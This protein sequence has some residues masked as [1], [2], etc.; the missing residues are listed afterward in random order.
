MA[1]EVNYLDSEYNAFGPWIFE[2][3]DI[4]PMPPLFVP[5]YKEGQSCLMMIKVPRNINRRDAKPGMDLY[6]YVIGMYEK[7]VYILKRKDKEVEE[8]K[9]YYDEVDSIENYKDMLLGRLTIHLN[10]YT[11]IVPY[12]AVSGDIIFQLVKIIRDRYVQKEYEKISLNNKIQT[13]EVTEIL[14]KNLINE[15]NSRGDS[16]DI[17]AFQPAVKLKKKYEKLVEKLLR[18]IRPKL[19]LSTIHLINR[20]ELLVI[21]RGSPINYLRDALYSYSF[22]YIPIERINNIKLE[23]FEEYNDLQIV[24]VSTSEKTYKFYFDERNENLIDFYRKLDSCQRIFP[25]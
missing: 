25:I 6:D 12:N 16:L 21:D 17:M 13:S 15:I 7:Y 9:F 11:T 23:R 20:R 24:Y 10:N 14:Y 8:T 3:T 2:V 19:L 18:L 22:T 1:G 4:N 5:Y